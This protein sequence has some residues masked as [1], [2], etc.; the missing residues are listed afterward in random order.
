MNTASRFPVPLSAE[1]SPWLRGHLRLPGDARLSAIA[2]ILAGMAKGE[3]VIENL[4]QSGE[5]DATMAALRQ[6]GVSIAERSGRLHV[7]GLGVGGLLTAEGPIDLSTAGAAAPL[8]I[9]LLGGF[10]MTTTFT[11]LAPSPASEAI[12]DF[13]E[14]NGCRVRRAG[15]SLELT[16]PRLGIPLD[17]ALSEAARGLLVPLLLNGLVTAGRSVLSL[18]ETLNDP[19]EQ[20]FSLFGAGLAAERK[21][22][23][24]RL[25]LEGL[26]PLRG[27]ALAVPGDP[28]LAVYPAVA[29]LIAPESEVAIHSVA[30]DPEAMGL[31]DA[32]AL[33]GADIEIGE[34]RRG[35]ADIVVRHGA[36]AGAPIP[37]ELVAG[38]EDYAILAVAA[39]FAEGETL[40]RI[41]EGVRRFTLSEALRANGV[42]CLAQAGA[43]LVRGQ[44]RVPGG[45]KVTTRLDPKLAMAFL[46]LGMAADRPVS[47]D[48]G[49]V[50]A[51]VFPGFTETFEQVGASFSRG[52]P[53]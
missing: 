28:A 5:A 2:L 21:A 6:L 18:P 33:M 43:L 30:L 31:L 36:L 42:T 46:V 15:A 52:T 24:I 12:L 48:D 29:A 19:A 16:G 37:A 39:A 9:G 35:G 22:G 38:P 1:R 14:R 23:G 41:G 44:R 25:T 26:S 3:S 32:L 45:G 8:L 51:D 40:L 10:A 4:R 47:I 49:A 27:Q 50:M 11:G 13:L 7:E 17:V 20:L 53:P 34:Q